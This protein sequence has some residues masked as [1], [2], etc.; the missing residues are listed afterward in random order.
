MSTVLSVGN[1]NVGERVV[2]N[3]KECPCCGSTFIVYVKNCV[4]Y[5][6]SDW[7]GGT[8]SGYQSTCPVCK[9]TF[10]V[11]ATS[12]MEMYRMQPRTSDSGVTD[13]ERILKRCD[14]GESV[15]FHD[16]KCYACQSHLLVKVKDCICVNQGDGDIYTYFT[17]G[18]CNQR[19]QTY[20]STK[21]V[22]HWNEFC[23]K[24]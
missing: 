21:N 1:A 19:L 12:S 14:L 11:G 17:C 6:V 5:S 9:F 18:N 22:D 20:G 2:H 15:A 7:G 16:Y 24:K 23:K 8:D 10:H 13:D 3:E 4:P